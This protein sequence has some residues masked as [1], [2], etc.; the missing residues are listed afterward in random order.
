MPTLAILVLYGSS[1]FFIFQ[2]TYLLY[3]R[4]KSNPVDCEPLPSYPH[5][6]PIW[7][8]DLLIQIWREFRRGA[9][10]EG[11]RKR[12]EK[13]GKTFNTVN[14][15]QHCIYTM[16]PEN[17][18]AVTTGN[19]EH[20]GKSSWVQE[21]S[22]HIGQG[23]LMN[24]GEAWKRSRDM[25]KPLF[26]RS[27]V[28][29]AALVEPHMQQLIKVIRKNGKRPFDFRE[30]SER[31]ILDVVTDFLFGKSTGCLSAS[32]DDDESRRFLSFVKTFEPPSGMF[33]AVGILAWIE[34]IPSYQQLIQTVNG[35]K[36]FFKRQLDM[37]TLDSELHMHK[38]GISCFRMMKNDGVPISQIQGEIQNIF[39]ASFDTTSA[40]LTNI[41]FILSRRQDIQQQLRQEISYLKRKPPTRQD[42]AGMRFLGYVIQEGQ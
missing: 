17:I 41:V 20:Y 38:S 22:K 9:L 39:F 21:A 11:M 18:R 5:L 23:I 30:L 36:R 1:L 4:S 2:R 6:D 8:I 28:D 42:L 37:V 24:E 25:L 12:H 31:F 13:Y 7:G 32:T 29:E 40:L 27:S 3:S 10:S 15:G 34:L 16:D 19:F 26:S 35:M 33:M 14:V